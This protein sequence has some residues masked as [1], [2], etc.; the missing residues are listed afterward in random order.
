ME[1]KKIKIKNLL[2]SY[3]H[4]G[5][6]KER[7]IFLILHGW[8]GSSDS[9][10]KVC[11]LLSQDFEIYA[12]DFPGFGK[13]EKLQE[14]WKV[15]DYVQLIENFITAI[16]LNPGI[17]SAALQP[18]PEK[19]LH[20]IAHSFGGRVAIKLAAKNPSYLGRLYLCAAAGIKHP[21]TIKQK[22]A[23]VAA[24]LGKNF[25]SGKFEKPA[26]KLLY[27]IIRE[28]DYY[29]CKDEIIKKTFQNIISEDLKEY[30]K[31]IK[32]PTTIIWGDKDQYTP[33]CDGKAI[34]TEIAGSELHI[35]KGAGHG[36]HLHSQ[37][38]LIK[39]IKKPPGP[40]INQ[41][42]GGNSFT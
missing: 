39:I 37:E 1:E 34:H 31:D 42:G 16:I 9:W 14:I 26:R 7:P 22:T 11:E 10:N 8:G 13:S 6:Q 12:P 38:S 36:I 41:R 29:E 21:P 15:D 5:A 2:I 3:K 28:K 23:A 24:K 33:L 40:T 19:N 25:L 27:K 35:I 30:L 18:H 17:E 20:I 4:F 32:V